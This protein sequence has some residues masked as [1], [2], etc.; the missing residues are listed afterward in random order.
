M[1]QESSQAAALN[2]TNSRSVRASVVYCGV[3]LG[4]IACVGDSESESVRDKREYYR[5]IKI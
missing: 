4:C 5:Y 1:N 2:A 3:R